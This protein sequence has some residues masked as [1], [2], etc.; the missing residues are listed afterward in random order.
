MGGPLRFSKWTDN[1]YKK[2]IPVANERI[3]AAAK[4]GQRP[5]LLSEAL[6][7]D[8]LRHTCASLL[9]AEGASIKA[10]QAQM[11]HKTATMTLDL[12]GHLFPDETERL[13]ERMDRA[14]EATISRLSRTQG[15]PVVVPLSKAAGQGA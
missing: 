6:R 1:Y 3:I 10:V 11:G 2:A 4:P 5:A 15:G 8:D 9:I 13:A 7:V 14:R 12:Y